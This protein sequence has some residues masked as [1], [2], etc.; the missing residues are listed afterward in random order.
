M[1]VLSCR[2]K[3]A[4]S[5]TAVARRS[6]DTAFVRVKV[7]GFQENFRAVESGVALRFPPHSMTRSIHRAVSQ[8]SLA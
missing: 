5:W 4:T 3:P 7:F 8:I 1:A 2:G 6:R